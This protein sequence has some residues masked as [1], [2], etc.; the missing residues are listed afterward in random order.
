M[1][2]LIDLVALAESKV[3]DQVLTDIFSNENSLCIGFSFKNDLHV[4]A[5]H[6]PNMN[7]FKVFAKFIDAQNYYSKICDVG[8]VGLAKV[9]KETIG[10]EL[11]KGEQ[12]S[13]WERRPL[14]LSQ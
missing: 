5:R 1:S 4:F 14:R 11:C 7:F 9:A 10:F 12:M 6:L 13:N 2:Y 8:Q 3:L